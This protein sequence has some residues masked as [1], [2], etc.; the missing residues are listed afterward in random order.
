[1]SQFLYGLRLH[2]FVAVDGAFFS[3]EAKFVTFHWN[4]ELLHVLLRTHDFKA[5]S[6]S[7]F[8]YNVNWH[9]D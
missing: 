7:G 2:N 5:Y 4:P 9:G 8:N 6:L 1:M 3:Y